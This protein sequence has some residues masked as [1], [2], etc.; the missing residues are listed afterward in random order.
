MCDPNVMMTLWEGRERAVRRTDY[1][2]GPIY[3]RNTF[4]VCLDFEVYR[5]LGPVFRKGIGHKYIE[6]KLNSTPG[7]LKTEISE[8]LMVALVKESDDPIKPCTVELVKVLL[9]HG[10]DP[11]ASFLGTTPCH[12]FLES[13]VQR[14]RLFGRDQNEQNRLGPGLFYD[15]VDL[16][17][18]HGADMSISVGNFLAADRLNIEEHWGF[19]VMPGDVESVPNGPQYRFRFAASAVAVIHHLFEE[20][21][22]QVDPVRYPQCPPAKRLETIFDRLKPEFIEWARKSSEEVDHAQENFARKTREKYDREQ[23]NCKT[24]CLT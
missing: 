21:D 5:G 4:E 12:F 6:E 2:G 18:R 15:L 19:C 3:F 13:Y 8:P 17:A 1:A 20:A 23:A 22:R 7:L 16:F 14:S 24:A 9:E 11:N 10:A